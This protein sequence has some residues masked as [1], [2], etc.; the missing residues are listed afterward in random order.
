MVGT[1]LM[2]VYPITMRN[3]MHC[4]QTWFLAPYV[5]YVFEHTDCG[6]VLF[7]TILEFVELLVLVYLLSFKMVLFS[8]SRLKNKCILCSLQ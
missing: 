1:A 5:S 6:V 3:P 8:L 7:I 2:S 4:T